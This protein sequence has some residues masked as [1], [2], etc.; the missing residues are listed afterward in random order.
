[1]LVFGCL[2]VS[3]YYIL[4]YTYMVKTNMYNKMLTNADLC[5][6]CAVLSLVYQH[7]YINYDNDIPYVSWI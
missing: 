6:S 2:I 1:M 5:G 4:A 3:N 7:S